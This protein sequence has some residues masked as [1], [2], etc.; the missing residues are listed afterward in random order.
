MEQVT[1]GNEGCKSNTFSPS[2]AVQVEVAR[3]VYGGEP[4]DMAFGSY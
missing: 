2:D 1:R 3:G 4:Y